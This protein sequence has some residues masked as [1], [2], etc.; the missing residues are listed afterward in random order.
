MRLEVF[1]RIE[2][3]AQLADDWDRLASLE[4]RHFPA[5][6]NIQAEIVERGWPFR[7]VVARAGGGVCAIGCVLLGQPR[8][9]FFNKT[10][11]SRLLGEQADLLGA[12]ILG[13]PDVGLAGAMLDLLLQDRRVTYLKLGDVD[14]T[15]G[16]YAAV[17]KRRW[18]WLRYES[19]WLATRRVIV[20]PERFT[21]YLAGLR[22]STQRTIRRDQRE[23]ARLNAEFMVMTAPEDMAAFI[24]DATTIA[25]KNPHSDFY[26]NP[27]AMAHRQRLYEAKAKAGRMLGFVSYVGENPC[28]YKCG[29]IVNGVYNALFTAYDPAYRNYEA[30]TAI[31]FY[32]LEYMI[33][34]RICL[35][36]DFG[37]RD[38]EY[39]ARFANAALDC[40]HVAMGTLSHPPAALT[41]VLMKISGRI[42]PKLFRLMGGRTGV[43][44]IKAWLARRREMGLIAGLVGRAPRRRGQIPRQ[45]ARLAPDFCFSV[46]P[47]ARFWGWPAKG[48]PLI[49]QAKKAALASSG[50]GTPVTAARCRQLQK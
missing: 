28:A 3:L 29:E 4:L 31:L 50:I 12:A 43:R 14:R 49:D 41:I 35:R 39:K 33:E 47:L 9:D 40:T 45:T 30:G 11:R 7:V 2:Q 21:D 38:M 48:Q 6:A 46:E 34:H 16:L 5:F 17:H 32:A 13:A 44:K 1:D 27:V 24:R 22:K 36:Y 10:L 15:S 37:G 25:A 42:K 8:R 18:A 26:V 20:F 19:D 23:F